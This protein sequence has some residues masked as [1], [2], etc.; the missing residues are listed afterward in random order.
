M[1]VPLPDAT[2]VIVIHA[3]LLTAVQPHPAGAVTVTV[4]P[5][6]LPGKIAR[7]GAIAY[8]HAAAERMVRW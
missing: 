4:S 3:A 8:V 6:P 1:P 5:P 2:V 7:V